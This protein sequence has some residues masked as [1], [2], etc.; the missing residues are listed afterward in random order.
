MSRLS[1]VPLENCFVITS[2]LAPCSFHE[3]A[4]RLLIDR[5]QFEK[6]IALWSSKAPFI[7]TYGRV[8]DSNLGRNL[9]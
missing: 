7:L 4:Q 6:R 3:P 9:C 1:Q 2:I 5:N 8:R